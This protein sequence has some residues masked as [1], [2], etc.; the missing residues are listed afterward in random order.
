MIPPHR[1]AARTVVVA[2][3]YGLIHLTGELDVA[4]APAV[5]GAVR[6]SLTS[7]PALLRIDIRGV[8]FCDCSGLG[9][10]L[11]AKA[12]A[13]EREPAS[14]CAARSGPPLPASWTPPAPPSIWACHPNRPSGAAGRG[15]SAD[16]P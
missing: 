8:S 6:E 9:A 15:K 3:R 4:T 5:R 12:E 10:L 13:A 11:W 7:R 14:I 2:G 1:R 16:A